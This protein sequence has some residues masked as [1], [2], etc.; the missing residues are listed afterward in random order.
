MNQC[1]TDMRLNTQKHR[2][3]TAGDGGCSSHDSEVLF[4]LKGS[5][6]ALNCE[7]FWYLWIMFLELCVA[8]SCCMSAVSCQC[9]LTVDVHLI[10]LLCQ[11][12]CRPGVLGTCC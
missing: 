8:V 3:S 12:E 6:G 9:M 7:A 10:W 1:G 11:K 4:V 5:Y 2:Q